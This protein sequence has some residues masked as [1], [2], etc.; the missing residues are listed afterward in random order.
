MAVP[1]LLNERIGPARHVVRK[2]REIERACRV[3]V[4]VEPAAA[5][6]GDLKAGLHG[7]PP[8]GPAH[9]IGELKVMLRARAV[10]LGASAREGVEHDDLRRSAVARP[11][12][13]FVADENS[14]TMSRGTKETV[15]EHSAAMRPKKPPPPI[16]GQ[17]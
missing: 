5:Q 1:R 17:Q 16:F 11:R 9:D 7:V 2:A 4:V 15:R 8:G 3:R 13:I 14:N 6:V 12:L 10:G